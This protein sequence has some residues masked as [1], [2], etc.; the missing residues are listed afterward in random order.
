[1]S[2]IGAVLAHYRTLDALR[3]P[4]YNLRV[5]F[6]DALNGYFDDNADESATA[7]F[8]RRLFEMANNRFQQTYH[9][10]LPNG[11]YEIIRWRRGIYH[12]KTQIRD[13]VAG[14]K[15]HDEKKFMHIIDIRVL[16]P[17]SKTAQRI[18]SI[19]ESCLASF[20]PVEDR[21][22]L[23][24]ERRHPLIGKVCK[25][26][27]DHPVQ[28][29]DDVS[30][31]YV[32]YSLRT[33]P[34]VRRDLEGFVSSIFLNQDHFAFE[35]MRQ[36]LDTLGQNVVHLEKL[37]IPLEQELR[38]LR[39]A[40]VDE[41]IRDVRSTATQVL[42]FFPQSPDERGVTLF[43]ASRTENSEEL[44][45]YAKEVMQLYYLMKEQALTH[46]LPRVSLRRF[47]VVVSGKKKI[48]PVDSVA[49]PRDAN[50]LYALFYYFP[51]DTRYRIVNIRVSRADRQHYAGDT[52]ALKHLTLQPDDDVV[53]ELDSAQVDERNVEQVKRFA[54]ESLY[55]SKTVP[56]DE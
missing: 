29:A 48:A 44:R 16:H 28:R 2:R 24:P 43:G 53:L 34:E 47:Q 12:I 5:Q 23:Q 49:L 27:S 26:R 13:V 45:S 46:M 56:L 31:G 51:F 50:V 8:Q 32:V 1:M 36:F 39:S 37:L 55:P 21:T 54:R 22:S 33:L 42:D 25:V 10:P 15:T 18:Q 30:Y 4:G 19:L 7:V 17:D 11:A 35:Q 6:T 52:E 40:G 3:V 14:R 20:A 9:K 41:I 38:Y